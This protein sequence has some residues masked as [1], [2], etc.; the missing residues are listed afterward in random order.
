VFYLVPGM[1]SQVAK[2][3]WS[4]GTTGAALHF[5]L[6]L[7]AFALTIWGLSKSAAF[8]GPTAQM[9]MGPTRCRS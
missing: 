4:V 1:L 7:A 3:A 6:A 8:A 5:F 2:V 9:F